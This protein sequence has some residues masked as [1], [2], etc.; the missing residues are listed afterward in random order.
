MDILILS[1]WF[2]CPPDNGS[3]L[4]AFHLIR[5]LAARHRVRLITGSRDGVD[6]PVLGT[7]ELCAQ[8]GCHEAGWCR[9]AGTKGII[10]VEER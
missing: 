10:E 6:A 9:G 8:L 5:H 7:E 4:R 3:R 2:P 1:T